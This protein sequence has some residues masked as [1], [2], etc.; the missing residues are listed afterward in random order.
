MT[1]AIALIG[2]GAIGMA[3]H[4]LLKAHGDGRAEV[5]AI[6]ARDTA[7]VLAQA[8]EAAPLLVG[9]LPALLARRPTLVV[10]CAGHQA[11]D[12]H[13][14]AVLLAGIDLLLVSVGAL[15]DAAREQS[16]VAA[17]AAADKRLILPA[18]AIGGI[19]WLAAARTAGLSSV[20]YRSRKPPQAWAGSAAEQHVDLAS[21]TQA[22][23]S[24]ARRARRPCSTRA[25]PTWRPRWR[26]PRW[27]LTARRWS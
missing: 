9:G 19:D 22:T 21:L 8:P 11:V 16:L 15:A 10:E 13:G 7:R 27:V 12:A 24:A 18:G 5:V 3:V 20:T 4:R 17:A 26:W 14:A 25:M 6:L 23:T 2:Y 1:Q